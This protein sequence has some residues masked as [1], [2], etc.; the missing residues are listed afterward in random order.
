LKR[1]V[2]IYAAGEA[3]SSWTE[4][5][6]KLV[7]GS[8]L[9]AQAV[10]I[11]TSRTGHF[12]VLDAWWSLNSKGMDYIECKLAMFTKDGELKETGKALRLAG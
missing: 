5:K 3:P 12:D 2:I 8:I 7:K 9:G 6:E 10:E 4:E 1:G 11:I